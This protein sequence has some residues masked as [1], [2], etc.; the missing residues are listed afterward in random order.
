MNLNY[1]ILFMIEVLD[2]Y[3]ANLQCTD[4]DITPTADTVA[5]L[6]GQQMLYKTVGNKGVVLTKIANAADGSDKNDT[7]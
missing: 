3:F 4:L 7:G 2:D 5:M 1:E 6:K